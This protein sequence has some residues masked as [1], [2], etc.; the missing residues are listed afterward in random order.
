MLGVMRL[1]ACAVVLAIS[2]TVWAEP[3]GETPPTLPRDRPASRPGSPDL[4]S[5]TITGQVLLS[6]VFGLGG[7]LAGGYLGFAMCGAQSCNT[8][9]GAAGVIIGAYAGGSLGIAG[10]TY[11]VGNNA[12]A[13]GSFGAAFGGALVGGVA[14]FGA[15]AI[16]DKTLGYN[17]PD[18]KALLETG[19]M[20]GGWIGGSLVGYY[21]TRHWKTPAL[22]RVRP[23]L[24]ANARGMT[25]GVGTA[26]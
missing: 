9:A 16:V 14:G 26:F 23:M 24:S 21:L 5:S 1:V 17:H 20:V 4:D 22:E 2:S 6:S 7:V 8:D 19:A 15:A 18:S 10:G 25:F 12:T 3:P 13:E 11:L